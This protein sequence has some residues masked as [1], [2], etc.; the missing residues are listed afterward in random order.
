MGCAACLPLAPQRRVSLRRVGP[1]ALVGPQQQAASPAGVHEARRGAG[2]CP[3]SSWGV[4]ASK[5]GGRTKPLGPE[6]LLACHPTAR[7]LGF[8]LSLWQ[9]SQRG[10]CL[11]RGHAVG[12]L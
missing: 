7:I 2:C 12:S 5:G 6:S 10:C 8:T 3:H 4:T 1:G 11:R 9:H